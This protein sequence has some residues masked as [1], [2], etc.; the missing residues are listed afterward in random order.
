MTAQKLLLNQAARLGANLKS[1]KGIEHLNMS[2]KPNSEN[3]LGRLP[4]LSIIIPAYKASKT[5]GAC[6]VSVILTRPRNSEVLVLLDGE[7]TR[8]RILHGLESLGI[9]KV[10]KNEINKGIS[11]SMNSLVSASRAPVIARMDADD[12]CLPGRF[13]KG[14]R[15]VERGHSD[16]VFGHAI[17]FGPRARPFFL[18]PQFPVALDHEKSVL[19]AALSNPF[20][21]STVVFRKSAFEETGGCSESIAEDFEL[22]L[23]A[24]LKGFRFRVLRR[25]QVLYRLHSN[26]HTTQPDFKAKVEND[27]LLNTAIRNHRLLLG[28]RLNLD[29]S[30]ITLDEEIRNQ[31]ARKSP[32]YR[33]R[34][35]IL[36]PLV[37]VISR[38]TKI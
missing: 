17:L 12:I 35:G 8:S 15:L 1:M 14:M 22:F 36:D 34:I 6:L 25:F 20:V 31:L 7:G 30:S 19:A 16:F 21:N 38:L 26:V 4:R 5:I 32:A 9:I 28:E 27:V 11:R 29:S 23:R 24:Q 33:F 3:H 13:R 10:L 2:E 18:I 37:K